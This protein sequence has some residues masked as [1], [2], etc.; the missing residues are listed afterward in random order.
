MFE[1]FESLNIRQL[2]TRCAYVVCKSFVGLT[3]LFVYPLQSSSIGIYEASD[4]QKQNF[5]VPVFD[6]TGKCVFLP[7]NPLQKSLYP[8]ALIPLLHSRDD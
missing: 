2:H 6:V 7:R 1:C 4:V 8:C 3:D 5:V